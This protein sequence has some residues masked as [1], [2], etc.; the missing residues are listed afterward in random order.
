MK[1][2]LQIAFGEI[3]EARALP[4]EGLDEAGADAART[5]RDEHD[6]LAQARIDVR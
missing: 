6:A 3:A 2:E 5:A 1:S 4:A